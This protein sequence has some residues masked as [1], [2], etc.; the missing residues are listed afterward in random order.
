MLTFEVAGVYNGTIIARD[1]ETGTLWAPFSGKGLEGPLAGRKL[2]R[3][4]LAMTR[5]ADWKARYPD[6]GVVWGPEQVRGGHG[7]WYEPGKWGIVGEMGLTIGA[8]DTRLPENALVYGADLPG[9]RR[10]YPLAGLK[11]RAWSTTRWPA[12]RSSCG[13]R[14]SSRRRGSSAASVRASHLPL[15]RGR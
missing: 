10:A 15:P 6:T 3:I 13:L 8:W 9:G 2:E 12:C 1:R 5:W 14:A 4:P 11:A 7:S